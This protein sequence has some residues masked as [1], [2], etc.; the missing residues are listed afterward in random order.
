MLNIYIY[1]YIYFKNDS[2][3]EYGS[4]DMMM[5]MMMI[6]VMRI[7]VIVIPRMIYLGSINKA[8]VP[9]HL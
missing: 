3:D 6:I 8:I 9:W 1:I 4:D 2:G 5:M 7:I